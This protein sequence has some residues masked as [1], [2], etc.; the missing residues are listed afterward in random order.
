MAVD[1]DSLI[2]SSQSGPVLQRVIQRQDTARNVKREVND[3]MI[4]NL[5]ESISP[6]PRDIHDSPGVQTFSSGLGNEI[7]WENSI[8]E[9]IA[10]KFENFEEMYDFFDINAEFTNTGFNTFNANGKKQGWKP[11]GGGGYEKNEVVGN[12]YQNFLATNSPKSISGEEIT[13]EYGNMNPYFFLSSSYAPNTVT[14]HAS[15]H[16][17]AYAAQHGNIVQNMYRYDMKS[18][19]TLI[20]PVGDKLHPDLANPFTTSGDWG[21]NDFSTVE[22]KNSGGP[23]YYAQTP[24]IWLMGYVHSKY[25][26]L[27]SLVNV[28]NGFNIKLPDSTLKKIPTPDTWVSLGTD[29]Y[30]QKNYKQGVSELAASNQRS[31]FNPAS[32]VGHSWSYLT[33]EEFEESR[34]IGENTLLLSKTIKEND[35]MVQGD[36]VSKFGRAHEL[37]AIWQGEEQYLSPNTVQGVD[38]TG[39]SFSL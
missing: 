23:A 6:S 11:L 27:E 19:L 38:I 12:T 2:E 13:Q 39:K 8:L 1:L 10:G 24:S 21:A 15:H 14:K 9:S 31:G 36:F 16:T 30:A 4:Q 26:E 17:N 20:N 37:L 28:N 25:D 5:F 34:Q 33:G 29:S 3:Q 35:G 32:W 22:G 18:A 7:D